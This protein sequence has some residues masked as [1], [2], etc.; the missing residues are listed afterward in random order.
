MKKTILVI[1]VLVIFFS[2]IQ[3]SH[4]EFQQNTFPK[5][6]MEGAYSKF[7]M[8]R[9]YITHGWYDEIVTNYQQLMYL[10]YKDEFIRNHPGQSIIPFPWEPSTSTKVLPLNCVVPAAPA[11]NLSITACRNQYE[12]ASFVIT[13]Q[14]D[15]SVTGITVPDLYNAQGNRIPADAIDVRLVKVW[16]Q[17]GDETI[18]NTGIRVLT[19]ELLLKDDS[20]VKV[21]YTNKVNYL[22]VSING[23][24]QYIDISNPSG[25][26]PSN[27]QFQDAQ[28]LQPFSLAANEN[29]QVWLTV[30]VPANT[31][32]GDY[33]GDI[34]ITTPSEAPVL[35][36]FTV[37]VPSFDLEPSPLEYAIYYTGKI[38]YEPQEGINNEWKTPQQ[39]ALELQDMK[40]HG[41]AYPTMFQYE[42]FQYK[43]NLTTALL[44]RNQSGLPMDHIYLH[45]G[46]ETGNPTSQTDLT[47][48]K[49][50]VIRWK[51]TCAQ[52]GFGQ[53]YIYGIDEGSN[54]I[55][56]SERPAWQAVHSPGAKVY[57]AVSDNQ[58]A[59]DVV[60]DLLDIVVFAYSP[61]TTQAAKWQSYGQRIFSYANP[62]SG[63][64]DPELYR[65]NYG[66]A[67]WNAGYDGEMIYAYQA[68]YGH[69][70]NDFDDIKYRDHVFAYPTSNGVIDTIQWE[71]FREGV[72]DTRYLAS[73][74]NYGGSDASIRSLII[75]SLSKGENMATVRKNVINQIPLT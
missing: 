55:L 75:A 67:L 13:A 27:A 6:T 72:D 3:I 58:E 8:I 63:V 73:L 43:W 38:P 42:W 34:A 29:K 54:D 17:A 9:D 23:V 32:S 16:Y 21:D 41:I 36:N 37:T 70:W 10:S 49:N 15:L 52:Y 24:Q 12:A 28:T 66:F 20:L 19:P 47:N 1:L 14:K 56:Q 50:N 53:V 44:L 65:K 61:N 31:P 39:Y 48:L 33:Y 69:I 74:K 64:E 51:N 40:E 71:G 59:V 5:I 30:H 45:D 57:A 26:F 68:G 11:N 62:E 7:S 60:G 2:I 18:K 22:K 25:T 46:I 35:M 4:I